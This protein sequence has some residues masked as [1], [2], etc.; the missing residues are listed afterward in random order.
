ME[1]ASS[2]MFDVECIKLALERS[3][4]PSKTF[5]QQMLTDHQKTSEQ[6]KGLAP[7]HARRP[8]DANGGDFTKRYH[9]DQEDVHENAVDLFKRYGDEG[10]NAELKARAAKM[11]PALGHH[12]KMATE[13][14]K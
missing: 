11:K 14:N 10:E 12:L 7:E 13:L 5:A 8:E 3:A 1:A 4:D 9:S 6:L 2:D